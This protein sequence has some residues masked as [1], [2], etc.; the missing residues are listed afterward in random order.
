MSTKRCRRSAETIDMTYESL[1]K[2]IIFDG[3][4]KYLQAETLTDRK[5]FTH[6]ITCRKEPGI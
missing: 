2:N 1:H 3:L 5:L 4:K 6:Y